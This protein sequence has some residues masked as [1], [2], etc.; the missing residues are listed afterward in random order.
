MIKNDDN[1]NNIM[2][3]LGFSQLASA[4]HR[5]KCIER[6]YTLYIHTVYCILYRVG[7]YVQNLRFFNV[8]I[9]R[10]ARLPP[11]VPKQAKFLLIL[12]K[13][14]KTIQDRETIFCSKV[15]MLK[16]FNI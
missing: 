3:G 7:Q 2:L 4:I 13:I 5:D 14:D 9:V 1:N 10:Q 8:F 16:F 15:P 12:A 6:E 11:K